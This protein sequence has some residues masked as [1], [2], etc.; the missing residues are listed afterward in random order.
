ME[1]E[2]TKTKLLNYVYLKDNFLPESG[3][4]ALLKIAKNFIE[5]EGATIVG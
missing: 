3:N 4:K 1:I 5:Y 2:E